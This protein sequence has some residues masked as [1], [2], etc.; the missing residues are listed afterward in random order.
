MS[1]IEAT[2][3]V[4]QA[5]EEIVL[6]QEV[7]IQNVIE[8]ARKAF[9]LVRGLNQVVRAVDSRKAKA[10]VIAEDCDESSYKNLISALCAQNQV[11]LFV[12]E[13]KEELG[14]MAGLCKRDI[15]GSAR[16]IVPTSSVAVLDLAETA[17]TKFLGF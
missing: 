10:V 14:R 1:E 3:V 2:P 4:Q 9:A 6:T 17:N 15:E 7:A 13:S 11:K 12:V 5:A 8:E 16:N